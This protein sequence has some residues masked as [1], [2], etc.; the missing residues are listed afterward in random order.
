MDDVAM[1]RVRVSSTQHVLDFAALSP[2]DFERLCLALIGKRSGYG[3]LEHLGVSGGDRG[4]DVVAVRRSRGGAEQLV[5]V[6]CKRLGRTPGI[7]MYL[8][9][10]RSIKR[11]VDA[12][13][14]AEPDVV[15]FAVTANISGDVRT[16]VRD[17]SRSLGFEAEFLGASELD[18]EVRRDG[19]LMVDFFDF[20]RGRLAQEGGVPFKRIKPRQLGSRRAGFVNRVAELETLD[21]ALGARSGAPSLVVINGPHGA[22]KSRLAEEW[23]QRQKESYPDGQILLDFRPLRESPAGS[24]AEALRSSLIALGCPAKKVPERLE[25][26]VGLYRTLTAS[27]RL[28]LLLDHVDEPGEVNVLLPDAPDALVVVTSNSAMAALKAVG[29]VHVPIV[30]LDREHAKLM[31]QTL[32]GVEAAGE[33]EEQARETILSYC[34]GLSLALELCATRIRDECGG[35]YRWLARELRDEGTRLEK[36]TGGSRSLEVVFASAYRSLSDELARAYRLIGQAPRLSTWAQASAVLGCEEDSARR[37]VSM[38]RSKHLVEF[39]ED[40]ADQAVHDRVDIGMHDLL[41]LH[42]RRAGLGVPSSESADLLRRMVDLAVRR[43]RQIDRAISPERLRLELAVT[44]E[45]DARRSSGRSDS[46]GV[47]R[48]PADGADA[49]RIFAVERSF[50]MATQAAAEIGGLDAAVCE[51]ADAMWPAMYSRGYNAEIA[52]VVGPAVVAADRLSNQHARCRLN[53]LL[54]RGLALREDW[55]QALAC[56]DTAVDIAIAEAD[57]WLLGSALEVK[58]LLLLDD[59]GPEH[60]LAVF[61]QSRRSFP[62]DGERGRAIQDIHIGMCL[63]RLGDGVKAAESLARAVDSFERLGDT[64]QAARAGWRLAEVLHD[65]GR[66]DDART[67]A[68]AVTAAATVAG[69]H[70]ARGRALL[71][72]ADLEPDGDRR[73][74]HLTGARDA[75]RD[76]SDESL[77]NVVEHRLG[78]D[79]ET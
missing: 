14:I 38:L 31:L 42:A 65:L 76:G 37:L 27:R 19:R 18:E 9:E 43:A 11:H 56:C 58:G 24:V 41:R 68:V 35:S 36:I 75:F 30:T 26:R 6:Q 70:V 49:S 52:D 40:L 32:V 39:R 7:A 23:V 45:A 17:E 1:D 62:V 60:A 44:A 25:D 28:M 64:T 29:A 50:L 63:A 34:G 73:R 54:A 59:H 3:R 2:F 79:R 72:L 5:Y 33:E 47:L 8:N 57:G 16:K 67:R 55:L 69:E 12:G 4:R 15:I 22:G 13:S 48:P 20:G 21:R 53:M 66:T 61:E 77:V 74:F 78:V 46:R 10:L 51:L 71:I